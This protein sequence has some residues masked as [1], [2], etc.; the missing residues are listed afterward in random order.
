MPDAVRVAIITTFPPRQC[1]I[2]RYSYRLYQELSRRPGLLVRVAAVNGS[3]CD[4]KYGGQVAWHVSEDDTAGFVR[5]AAELNRWADVVL[6]QHEYG[7][8]G[9]QAGTSILG[10]L[11]AASM[12][13]VAMLHTILAEPGVDVRRVTDALCS[14]SAA[15]LVPGPRSRHVLRSVYRASRV[16]IAEIPHGVDR[17]V[18]SRLSGNNPVMLGFGY[19]GPNKGVE[20]VLCAMPFLAERWPDLRYRYMGCQHPNEKRRN[21]DGYPRSLRRLAN[22]LN[23]AAN[24]N[25]EFQHVSDARLSR[26]LA[27]AAICVFPYTDLGQAVSGTLSRSMAAGR[28]IVATPFR[29]ALEVSDYGAV[30]I[31][32]PHDPKAVA[33]AVS[34]IIADDCY[35]RSL[36]ESARKVADSMLWSKVAERYEQI[37]L[38]V[39]ACGV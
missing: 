34:F 35:R 10:F 26:A 29:H 25:F 12:P 21:G 4:R 28:A 9:R 16:R 23:V 17:F 2:A 8:F 3:D 5:L 38:S 36:E 22:Q 7:L 27:E 37:L 18:L 39:L 19:L 14:Q 31:V 13:I 6:I 24:V 11:G 33:D 20:N 15:V 32:P 30:H 1:G